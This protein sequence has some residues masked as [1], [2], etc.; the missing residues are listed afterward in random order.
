MNRHNNIIIILCIS[1]SRDI[2]WFLYVLR[3]IVISCCSGSMIHNL[4][5]V[6]TTFSSLCFHI[7]LKAEK[8]GSLLGVVK[9]IQAKSSGSEPSL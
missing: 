6:W 2:R 4:Y 3:L 5:A 7:N 1:Y 8:K 9:I